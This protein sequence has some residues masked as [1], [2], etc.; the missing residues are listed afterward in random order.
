MTTTRPKQ[1]VKSIQIVAH[2]RGEKPSKSASFQVYE[3]SGKLPT[4][5]RMREIL[6]KAVEKI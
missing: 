3:T 5:E 2:T 1:K 6:K 4:V